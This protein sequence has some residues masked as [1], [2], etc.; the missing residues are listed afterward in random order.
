MVTR[1][2]DNTFKFIL[3]KGQAVSPR[4]SGLCVIGYPKRW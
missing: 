1:G 2:L 3:H 4:T